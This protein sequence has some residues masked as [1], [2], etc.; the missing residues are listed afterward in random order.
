MVL[1]PVP[2]TALPAPQSDEYPFGGMEPTPAAAGFAG[3][4][5]E[6]A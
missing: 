4:Y 5:I 2:S 1:P 6:G 3:A